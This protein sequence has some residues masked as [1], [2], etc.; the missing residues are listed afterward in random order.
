M[1]GKTPTGKKFRH[2]ETFSSLFSDQIF[3]FV[4]PGKALSGDEMSGN[5]YRRGITVSYTHLTLPTI[6]LV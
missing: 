2:L 3:K 1:S 6:L 4:F 5:F